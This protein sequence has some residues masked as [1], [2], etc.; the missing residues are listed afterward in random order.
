MAPTGVWK[1]ITTVYGVPFVTMVG[2]LMMETWRAAKW[3]TAGLRLCIR[4][5]LMD[6]G[7]GQF[8][9]ITLNVLDQRQA[10]PAA[11]PMDGASTIAYTGKMPALYAL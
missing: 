7:R 4:V 2:T 9:W 5:R 1:C 11:R 8:G 3:D 10:Y 6:R